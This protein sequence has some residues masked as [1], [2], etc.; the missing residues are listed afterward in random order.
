MYT[1]LSGSGSGPDQRIKCLHFT[2]LIWL[3]LE[4]HTNC[5]LGSRENPHK[6]SNVMTA[7]S[8]QHNEQ[9]STSFVYSLFSSLSIFQLFFAITFH[10]YHHS[11]NPK[12]RKGKI[13]HIYNHSQSNLGLPLPPATWTLCS[14]GCSYSDYLTF[15]PWMN[16]VNPF[17]KSSIFKIVFS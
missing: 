15:F 10:W 7:S 2:S 17:W 16:A 14:T 11:I 13:D 12:L 3:Y 1:F 6:A 8:Q 5:C 4:L 9:C